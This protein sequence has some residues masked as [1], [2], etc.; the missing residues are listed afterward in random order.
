MATLKGALKAGKKLAGEAATKKKNQLVAGVG[1]A[2]F[3]SGIVGGALNKSFQKKFGAQES[4]DTRVADALAAQTK[5]QDQ[6]SAVL[7]RIETIVMNIADNVYNLAGVMNAQVVSMQE[8][9]KIQQERAY[10]EEAD[11]EEAAAE[12]KKVQGPSAAASHEPRKNDKGGVMGMIANLAGSI[13]S[14]K[15]LFKG[16]LK[17]FGVLALGITAALGV[18]ALAEKMSGDSTKE[19]S[20]PASGTE[21]ASDAQKPEDG[22]TPPP[23][24]GSN[25]TDQAPADDTEMARLQNR[26]KSQSSASSSS[27]S[28]TASAQPQS[29]AE[30]ASPEKRASVTSNAAAMPSSDAASSPAPS[31]PPA[32]PAAPPPSV[33]ATNPAADPDIA[34]LEEYFNKP[35]NAAEKAQ[36]VD[37]AQR[38]IDIKEGIRATKELMQG[39]QTPEEKERN[40]K[41]LKL[42]EPR[43]EATKKEKK[44]ILDKARKAVGITP[45]SGQ[46]ASPVATSASGTEAAAPSAG[47]G[48]G[49]AAGGAMSSGGGGGGGA[50]PVPAAPSTGAAISSSSTAVAAASE[51]PPPKN[52]VSEFSTGSNEGTAAPSP[53]PSPIAN[54]GSLDI[55][56][57]FGSES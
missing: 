19:T 50:S 57:S 52:S 42:L 20:P 44:A 1:N 30:D 8:A 38:Q 12:A 51:P 13:G 15:K 54:R 31:A 56:T 43:L 22:S 26:A 24:D 40:Q 34:K 53:I 10:K 6:N 5:V 3:G 32:V 39:P 28:P 11:K 4:K 41:I 14:T 37:V 55:D 9:Q 35:E 18:A 25:S 36:L 21:P 33:A 46:G 45:S 48:G 16:F 7:T 2:V 27:S 49:G 47:S 23:G 29:S 17:K